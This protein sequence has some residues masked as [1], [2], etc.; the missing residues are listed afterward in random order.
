MSVENKIQAAT[1][2][3]S[4]LL[5]ILSE[6]DYAPPALDQHKRYI[7]DLQNEIQKLDNHIQSL[8]A[9]RA[10]ELKEHEKY[11]DSNM[12][13][14]AY[15]LSGKTDKFQARASKEEREYFDALQDEHRAKE[16]RADLSHRLAEANT[17]RSD[18][19]RASTTHRLAQTDLAALYASIFDGPTPGFPDEDAKERS[20]GAALQRYHDLRARTEA[21]GQAVRILD[22]AQGKMRGALASMGEAAS[23]SR[24]DM[25]GGGTMADMMERSALG[26][27]E[28][29]VAQCQT[30]VAQAQRMS[31]GVRGLPPVDIARGSLMS[32][33]FFDNVFTDM[34]FHDKIKQSMGELQRAAGVLAQQVDEARQR[35][36]GLERELDVVAMALEESRSALQEAREVAFEQ[37]LGGRGGGV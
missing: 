3:N 6:T 36:A 1:S 32:D 15:K 35:C 31:A 13:R 26:R 10:K 12:K 17:A 4:R 29:L 25:F 14:F 20:A 2:Q 28:T 30:Q 19:E 22:A 23:Y 34:A 33:V 11:R 37:V 21:E 5:A 27:A 8:E 7:G 24:M 18:L 16:T 9:N